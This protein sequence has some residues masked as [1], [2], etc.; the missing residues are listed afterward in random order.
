MIV[1]FQNPGLIDPRVIQ[2]MGVNVKPNPNSIGYF[3]TGLKFAIATL[4]RNKQEISIFRGLERLDFSVKSETIR[5]VPFSIIHMNE[6]P[7]SI[8]TD[9]GRN[10]ELWMAMRELYSNMLD[11]KGEAS[12]GATAPREGHTTIQVTGDAFYLA[13]QK[14]DEVFL[15]NKTPI[16]KSP[17]LEIYPGRTDKMYYRGIFVSKMNKMYRYTY[18]VL[19]PQDLTEDR[20]LKYIHTWWGTVGFAIMTCDQSELIEQIISLHDRKDFE[21]EADFDWAGTPSEQFLDAVGN[22]GRRSCNESAWNVWLKSKRGGD[23]PEFEEMSMSPLDEKRLA[24]ATAFLLP[25]GYTPEFEIKIAVDLGENILGTVRNSK[26][27]WLSHRV[28][29]M[30]TKQVAS[31]LYEE[32]VHLKHGFRDKTYEMQNF[33]FDKILTMLE[34]ATGEPL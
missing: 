22:L 33:L 8:T 25:L 32:W 12:V 34:V 27:I 29:E 16:Y 4:L 13:F 9:M 26:T 19:T 31:T 1:S 17:T 15:I 24:K 18:N 10:W 7:L 21:S 5:D 20:T 14:L 3:G 30:G 2:Y 11:E 23:I 28:F 6:T